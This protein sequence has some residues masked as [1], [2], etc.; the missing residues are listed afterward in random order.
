MLC[1]FKNLLFEENKR[2][3]DSFIKL[4]YRCLQ[5]HLA[6][7]KKQQQILEVLLMICLKM[8]ISA[9]SNILENYQLHRL[10]SL[11]VFYFM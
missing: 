1:G 2:V 9:F 3:D 7:M 5:T 11:Y 6:D 10:K 8:L 4:K